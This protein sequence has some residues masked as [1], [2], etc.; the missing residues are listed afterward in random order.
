M[1]AAGAAGLGVV[2]AIP[3]IAKLLEPDFLR[4]IDFWN[5]YHEFSS[6]LTAQIDQIL[7]AAPAAEITT[8]LHTDNGHQVPGLG[9]HYYYGTTTLTDGYYITFYKFRRESERQVE[10]YYECTVWW[11][12]SAT[13]YQ[14]TFD[15]FITKL[16][17]TSTGQVEVLHI[18]TASYKTEVVT[19]RKTYH[20]PTPTQMSICNDILREYQ[21][22]GNAAVL[23]TGAPGTYKSSTAR[24]LK[25]QYE[26]RYPGSRV[27]LY[28][29]F[30]PSATGVDIVNIALQQART[31]VPVIIVIDEIDIHFSKALQSA[32]ANVHGR[33]T[34]T[35]D[36]QSF[37]NMLD[38][39]RSVS[40]VMLIATTNVPYDTLLE[41]GYGVFIR[42]GRFDDIM[43]VMQDSYQNQLQN[44]QPAAG[45]RKKID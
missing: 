43:E 45:P 14:R 2:V 36:K 26:H 41:R 24:V 38:T 28:D 32:T 37:N 6:S 25:K 44:R 4:S 35:D 10:Y 29:N 17:Q 15:E 40:N 22:T 9:R 13:N 5:S 21:R 18:S 27:L 16:H 33:T 20:P 31:D 8:Q 11:L 30:N 19:I 1:A 39:I 3:V 7:L 42:S 12:W 23:L 34:Y